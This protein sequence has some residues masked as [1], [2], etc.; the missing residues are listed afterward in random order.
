MGAPCICPGTETLLVMTCG[1]DPQALSE[2]V[3]SIFV[4]PAATSVSL[5]ARQFSART[6]PFSS[7]G[8]I[9]SCC[10]IGRATNR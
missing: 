1:M 7:F 5:K 9:L 3:Y 10:A 8:V 6:A 4:I 2:H